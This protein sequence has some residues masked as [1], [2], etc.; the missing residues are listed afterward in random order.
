M[1]LR[2]AR[3]AQSSAHPSSDD[4]TQL[5]ARERAHRV[6]ERIRGNHRAD[7]TLQR[8]YN[9]KIDKALVWNSQL[10]HTLMNR[11]CGFHERPFQKCEMVIF[12]V[13]VRDTIRVMVAGGLA[14]V[15]E[16]AFD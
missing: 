1:P 15:G 10:V 3:C 9:F 13:M 6:S 11:F 14:N 8:D 4:S 2:V 16:A 12:S 5:D 7:A